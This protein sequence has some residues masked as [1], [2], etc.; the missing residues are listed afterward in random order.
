[1][2]V[3]EN[4]F[5][6]DEQIMAL[7]SK[8]SGRGIYKQMLSD[9]DG[10]GVRGVNV[11]AQWPHLMNSDKLDE[12]G[13]VKPKTAQ[14]LKQGFDTAKGSKNALPAFASID[15]I[16]DGDN[17]FLIRNSEAPAAPAEAE[18]AAV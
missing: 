2:A 8:T 17:V 15:V 3:N 10:L 1:M 13:V 6:T 7:Q 11:R 4:A 16:A 14:T 18:V 12:N 5:L 9:F